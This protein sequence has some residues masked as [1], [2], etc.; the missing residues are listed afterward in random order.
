MR[1]GAQGKGLALKQVP[2]LREH[3]VPACFC[4]KL[5]ARPLVFLLPSWPYLAPGSKSS[6]TS[7]HSSHDVVNA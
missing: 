3:A 7:L 1:P 2:A 5:T 6:S 4:S